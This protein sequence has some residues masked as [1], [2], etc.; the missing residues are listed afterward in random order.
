MLGLHIQQHH[1]RQDDT[2]CVLMLI[3]S[4]TCT[5]VL[6]GAHLTDKI[7]C[8]QQRVSSVVG[9]CQNLRGTSNQVD[10]YSTVQ[11]ALGLGHL[12]RKLTV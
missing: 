12:H 11:R 8:K 2:D 10:T 6:V 4:H 5:D 1:T 9:Q 7:R 3:G